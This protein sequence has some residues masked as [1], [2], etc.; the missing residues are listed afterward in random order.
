MFDLKKCLFY[1]YRVEFRLKSLQLEMKM[2]YI[3]RLCNSGYLKNI[4]DTAHGCITWRVSTPEHA[5]D[6]YL[7]LYPWVLHALVKLYTV[8]IA[9]LLR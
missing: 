5:V 9:L 6:L 1:T 8:G 3:Y 2:A 7:K 4:Q